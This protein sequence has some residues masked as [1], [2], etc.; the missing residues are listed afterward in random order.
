MN[1]IKILLLSVTLLISITGCKKYLTVEPAQETTKDKLFAS[2]Q[3]YTDALVGIYIDMRKNYSPSSFFVNGGVEFMAQL[4]Y[5]N[6]PATLNYE[7][8]HHDY[9]AT[10]AD[11]SLGTTFINQYNVLANINSLLDALS[12]QTIL[13]TRVAKLIE[14]ESLALRAFNHF[15]MIRLYGPMPGNAG[16]KT[17][18]PYVTSVTKDAIPYD[19]YTSYMTKLL[20]DLDKAEP[21]LQTYDPIVKYAPY[22]LNTT[23][24]SKSEY[25]SMFWYYRQNRMNYYAV[26]GLKARVYLWMGD[27]ENALKYALMVINAVNT[28]NNTKKFS[29][30]VRANLSAK[31]YVFFTEHLFGLNMTTFD[32]AGMSS[33]SQA[34]NVTPQTRTAVDLYQNIPD[35]RSSLFYSVYSYTVGTTCSSTKKY[36]EMIAATG[37]NNPFSV[38]LIRL[39]EMY[40]IASEC[41]PLDEA[42]VYFATYRTAREATSIT[43]TDVNRNSVLLTEY[44]KEFYGEGQSFYAYKRFGITDMLWSDHSTGEAQY[45]LPLPSLETTNL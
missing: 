32:D 25:T 45:V 29:F 34:S 17:Y 30:G 4:Y 42:N 24:A 1:N 35:L 31:N 36:A 21:L 22:S 7:L 28:D 27:K 44:I 15:D 3:G 43:L 2:T 14:G 40:L 9:T 26:L 12:T 41:A 19:T 38:P 10:E 37:N 23:W 5:S 18:L 39:S 11:Q 6:K 16:T 20:A 33:G 8:I 13:E